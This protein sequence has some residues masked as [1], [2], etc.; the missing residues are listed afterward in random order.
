MR[1]LGKKQF[2]KN[3]PLA[4]QVQGVISFFNFVSVFLFLRVSYY[5][6]KEKPLP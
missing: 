2:V 3:H 4:L 1:N 6:N 5:P